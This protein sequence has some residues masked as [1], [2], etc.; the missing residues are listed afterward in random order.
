MILPTFVLKEKQKK[1]LTCILSIL[2]TTVTQDCISLIILGVQIFVALWGF[3]NL[4]R[5]PQRRMLHLFYKTIYGLKEKELPRNK[6]PAGILLVPVKGFF[7]GGSQNCSN[8]TNRYLVFIRSKKSTTNK[9]IYQLNHEIYRNEFLLLF[10]GSI[11]EN[12]LENHSW[13]IGDSVHAMATCIS[14]MDGHGP[15]LNAVTNKV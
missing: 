13:N 9:S 14:W 8:N 12:Y 3:G 6:N 5:W 7:Y 15:S 2:V 11:R 1:T 4:R 10:V